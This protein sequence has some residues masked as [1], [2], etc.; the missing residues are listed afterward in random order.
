MFREDY[1]ALEKIL[2]GNG[3]FNKIVKLLEENAF[4]MNSYEKHFYAYLTHILATLKKINQKKHYS[5][6][7]SNYLTIMTHSLHEEVPSVYSDFF[8]KASLFLR[9][10]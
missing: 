8:E 5:K 7:H 9:E 3:V 4:R 2:E 1:S 10:I 6:I